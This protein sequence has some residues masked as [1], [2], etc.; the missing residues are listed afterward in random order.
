MLSVNE[1]VLQ[2]IPVLF[3]ELEHRKDKVKPRMTT[4]SVCHTVLVASKPLTGRFIKLID[5]I[6]FQSI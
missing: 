4:L 3:T 1:N 2:K 6:M 5:L